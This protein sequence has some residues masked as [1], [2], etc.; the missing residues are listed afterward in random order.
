MNAGVEAEALEPDFEPVVA[1][2]RIGRKRVVG[3]HRRRPLEHVAAEQ[4]AAHVVAVVGVAIVGRVPRNDRL[5]LRRAVRRDLQAVEAA[6]RVADHAHVAGA[7]GLLG[8]PREYLEGVELLLA[9]VLVGDQPV[10]V[11]GAADIDA[12]GRVAVLGEVGVARRVGVGGLVVLAVRQVLEDRRHRRSGGVFR[13]PDP[14]G[15]PHAVGQRD[16]HIGEFSH[17][18]SDPRL[19][20]TRLTPT[21]FQSMLAD[22]IVHARIEPLRGIL[23]VRARAR[24]RRYEGEPWVAVC[25]PRCWPE[26]RV[27]DS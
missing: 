21:A 14:S 3:A 25:S 19:L 24:E 17:P 18:H 27:S 7:P 16:P 15:E 20:T 5:E 10:G 6:P 13:Q 4:T 1:E 26:R 2:A 22:T 12:N 23:T 11:A 8:K 9:R